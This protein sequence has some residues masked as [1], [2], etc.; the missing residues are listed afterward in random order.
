MQNISKKLD[1]RTLNKVDQVYMENAL[2]FLDEYKIIESMEQIFPKTS[3][4]LSRMRLEDFKEWLAIAG[5]PSKNTSL[6]SPDQK[7][8]SFSFALMHFNEPREFPMTIA[9]LRLLLESSEAKY[10]ELV[11]LMYQS[12]VLLDKIANR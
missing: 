4:D 9:D 10:Y 1:F 2:L 5:S 3:F 7:L 6:N 8:V 11:F 12:L